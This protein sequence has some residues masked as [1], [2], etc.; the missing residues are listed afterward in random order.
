MK[1]YLALVPLV[2]ATSLGYAAPAPAAPSA[3][4]P[5]IGLPAAPTPPPPPAPERIEAAKV[6]MANMHFADTLSKVLDAR[7]ES[8]V[9]MIDQ[10]ASSPP[11][12]ASDADE[13]YSS[14]MS[15]EACLDGMVKVYASLFTVDE[16]KGMAAFYSSPAGQALV[17]KTMELQKQSGEVL[18]KQMQIA[19]PQLQVK[20]KAFVTAHPVK[21]PAPAPSPAA[22]V[23]PSP[24]AAPATK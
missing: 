11:N 22:P 6:L 12:S 17:A 2:L 18:Q 20:Q 21:T 13:T 14:A 19:F 16:L 8:I 10:S 23:P 1:S 7:K 3:A 4:A 9:R 15:T 24:P 5:V